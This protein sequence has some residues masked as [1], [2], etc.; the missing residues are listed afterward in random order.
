MTVRLSFHGAASTVTGSCFLVEH[1]NGR[2]LVDCGLFQGTKTIRE[3]NYGTFPF[4]PA[5]VDFVLLT[6]AHIDHSGLLPK[7]ARKG[8][9]GPIFATEATI[10]LLRFM[11]PDS[12]HIQESEVDRLNARNRQRGRPLVEAIYTQRDAERCLGLTRPCDYDTWIEPGPGV[13]ARWWN[14]GHILGSASIEIEVAGEARPLKLLFSGDI[15]P[16]EKT[17]HEDP[18]AP[19]GPDILVVESTYGDRDRA[20]VTLEQRRARLGQEIRDALAAGGNL[21]IP[22]FAVERSQELLY[23]IL[24]LIQAGEI[25]DARVFLDSPLAVEATRVFARHRDTLHEAEDLGALLRDPHLRLCISA[26]DSKAINRIRS[27]AIILA[28]SGMCEAGRI[29]HHLK[30]HLWRHDSTVLFVGYQAPGTLGHL[31]R[32]GEPSVRIH[33]EEVAVKARIREID[34]FSAHADQRELLG[35]VKSRLPVACGIFLTHGEPHAMETLRMHLAEIGVDPALVRMPALDATFE[36]AA[37]QAPVA[38][39]S[40]SRLPAEQAARAEDWHNAYARLLLEIGQRLRSLPDDR[41]RQA[42][43]DSLR[44]AAGRDV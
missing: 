34:G 38:L 35:W 8:F 19:A 26:E 27:G 4:N 10:D 1:P 28:A 40:A 31:I 29:R 30:Q 43:L 2:F 21:L 14:A 18:E 3:L 6:H 17:F 36:L 41:S 22:A 5:A 16:I 25:P 32:S 9:K 37:G 7:L 15:G 11:L 24:E 33:G 20:D 23:T 42:L 39:A 44:V 13:R 12:G